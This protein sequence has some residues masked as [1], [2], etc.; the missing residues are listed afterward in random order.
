MIQHTVAFT[1]IHPAG[2]DAETDFLTTGRRALT[3][4]PGVEEFQINR[5]V[6]PKSEHAF[7]FSMRF[8][9]KA[10]YAAYNAHPDH[11]AFVEGRWV[12]EVASFQELDLVPYG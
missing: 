5:Q 3:G 6:S 7:Q 2:S 10:A 4:I 1:L 9:D 11:T 8:A 12:P